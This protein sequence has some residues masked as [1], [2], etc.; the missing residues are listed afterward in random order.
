MARSHV[1]TSSPCPGESSSEL[2]VRECG[3]TSVTEIPN[4]GLKDES[5]HSVGSEEAEPHTRPSD[6]GSDFNDAGDSQVHLEPS[7]I[8]NSPSNT[9]KDSAGGEPP[10]LGASDEVA[11]SPA[12]HS[13]TSNDDY[14]VRVEATTVLPGAEPNGD[15]LQGVIR[16]LS[17]ESD[18]IATGEEVGVETTPS[19][20]AVAEA[21]KLAERALPDAD[22]AEVEESAVNAPIEKES[23]TVGTYPQVGSS[24]QDR[25][26]KP[27]DAGVLDLAQRTEAH[28]APAT[29]EPAR[30]NSHPIVITN[31]RDCLEKSEREILDRLKELKRAYLKLFPSSAHDEV[32]A[33]YPDLLTASVTCTKTVY[34]IIHKLIE[35]G[36][37]DRVE[38]GKA[39]SGAKYRIMPEEEV[40][41]RRLEKGLTHWV[42]VGTSRK[43]VPDPEASGQDN[44]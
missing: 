16:D 7:N 44:D 20:D 19:N 42:Q 12:V 3:T 6:L 43:A 15:P 5:D 27:A 37:I 33:A 8:A 38:A 29:Q 36:F 22:D 21:D 4:T 2:S 32:R 10:I 24:E 30:R 9:P 17:N 25:L 11:T 40:K 39:R 41:K 34:R 31:E 26:S 1:S 14:R 23:Q 28:T 35:K 18:A 13:Q